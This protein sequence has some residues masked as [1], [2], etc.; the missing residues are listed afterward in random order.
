MDQMFSDAA[1]YDRYMGR[2]SRLV[3]PLFVDFAQVRDG[4]RVLDI[5][6]GTGALSE[7]VA[8]ATRSSEI[9]GIDLSSSFIEYARAHI[10]DPRIRFDIGDALDL[11]YPDASFDK[12]L[13]LL[14]LQLIP[15]PEKAASEM[16]RVTR[17]G[18]SV[19]A[20]AWDTGG[21]MELISIF[22]D[23]AVKLDPLAEARREKHRPYTLRGQL[24]ALWQ[25]SGLKTVEET[26]LEIQMDF[27]SF[28]DFWLPH[29]QGVGPAGSYVS[30]LSPWRRDALRDR[31]RER[32]LGER[33]DGPF[34]LQAQ[35]WAVQGTVPE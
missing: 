12:S 13:A 29:L 17:P 7:V 23:E 27:T 1:A 9:I 35:A 31:L 5:G 10:T 20:C 16:R 30:A 8:A 21:G 34:K 2:W 26:G 33:P 15:Q 6:C 24:S 19:A 18:G 25:M 28:D 32:L 4:E 11:P 14:V 22:W 3:A